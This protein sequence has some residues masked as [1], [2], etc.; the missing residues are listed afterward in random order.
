[1]IRCSICYSIA[2]FFILS[3]GFD[4]LRAEDGEYH[5]FADKKAQSI[6]AVM[7]SVSLDKSKAIIQRKKDGEKFEI[8]ILSLSLNDQQYIKD[9]LKVHPIESSYNI[10]FDLSKHNTSIDRIRR[11]NGERGNTQKFVCEMEF[12][13]LS[14]D[15]LKGVTLEYYVITVHAIHVY[16]DAETGDPVWMV[17]VIPKKR[18]RKKQLTKFKYPISIK[19]GTEKMEDLAYNFAIKVETEE[20][21]LRELV[22]DGGEIFAE[23]KIG[24]LIVRLTDAA[25]QEIGIYRSADPAIQDMPWERITQLPPGNPAGL[26]AALAP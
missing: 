18:A 15:T 13:N 1:M 26:P 22:I 24:G 19:H 3:G 14:R 2:L 7:I 4:S 12:K 10:E 21:Q 23:D 16:S 8:S 5:S 6:E 17:N 9:W 11:T 20:L 25:G